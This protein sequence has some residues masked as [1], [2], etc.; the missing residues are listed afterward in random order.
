MSPRSIKLRS[1]DDTYLYMARLLDPRVVA[2]LRA[3][4]ESVE[5]FTKLEQRRSACRSRS[6]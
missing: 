3:T 4:Q 5:E 2:Q 6:P 1:Y